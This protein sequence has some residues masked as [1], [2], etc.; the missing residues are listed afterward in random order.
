MAEL[1]IIKSNGGVTTHALNSQLA[2]VKIG[3]AILAL[4]IN[5][6]VSTR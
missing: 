5:L 1:N 2:L 6:G 3:V 4:G